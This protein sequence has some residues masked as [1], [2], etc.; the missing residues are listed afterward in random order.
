MLDAYGRTR[1]NGAL[2][3]DGQGAEQYAKNLKSNLLSLLNRAKS[4]TYTAP[5]VRRV[6]I[7]KGN[8]A[9][10]RPLGIPTFEDKILQN[11]VNE[12]LSLVYEQDFLPCSYGFRPGRNA[13]QM[14]QALRFQMMRMAGGYVLEVDIEKF[15]GAPGQAWRF[16]RV[17]F[18]PRHGASH[19]TGNRALGAWR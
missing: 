7:P 1:K 10:L 8:G 15:F 12:L 11:A 18:P 6:Y 4:G 3:V 9:Q 17:Q 5:P 16:Q 13:H 2:G 14:L 19:S